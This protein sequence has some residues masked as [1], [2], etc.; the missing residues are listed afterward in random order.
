MSVELRIPEVGES[1]SEVQIADWLNQEG[2][3]T[4]RGRPWNQVQVKRVLERA[5]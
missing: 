1:I 5:G 2:H 4:R 3:T